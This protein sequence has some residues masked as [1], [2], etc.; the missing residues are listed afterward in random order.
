MKA[1]KFKTDKGQQMLNNYDRWFGHL[2]NKAMALLELGI[3]EGESLLLW[4]D[5]FKKGRIAGL[6]ME[7]VK[8]DPR[9]SRVKIY[10]GMQDE[11]SLLRKIARQVAPKGFD[12]IIDDASHY[13]WPTKQSFEFLFYKHLKNG[14][15]YVI[16]D[17]GTGYWPK[18]PDGR[19]YRAKKS[20]S[21]KRFP[22]HDWGMVGFVKQLI[23]E[24]GV[25]D[26]TAEGFGVGPAR[27]SEIVK[28]EFQR[29][30][31]AVFKK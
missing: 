19:A 26:M 4:N 24:L 21:K 27:Q 31:V 28:I 1:G 23:D 3:L 9:P 8:I 15:I 22:S 11:K 12:I 2:K 16:E 6:D 13:G 14:G 25:D 20:W 7:D 10:K 29:G 5:Y 30:Q 17:W 18:W